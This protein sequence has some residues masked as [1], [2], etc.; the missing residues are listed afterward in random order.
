MRCFHFARAAI[1]ARVAG[2]G[3]NVVPLSSLWTWGGGL[4]LRH[5]FAEGDWENRSLGRCREFG[6]G[7]FHNFFLPSVNRGVWRY[8]AE[9]KNPTPTF[10]ENSRGRPLRASRTWCS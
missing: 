5:T 1:L 3:K 9:S 4:G 8:L 6:D 7:C 2:F 10:G